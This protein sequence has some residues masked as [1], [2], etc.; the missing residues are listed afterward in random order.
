M[1]W[2]NFDWD[3]TQFRKVP[4]KITPE[5]QPKTTLWKSEWFVMARDQ[6]IFF[7][8][9]WMCQEW[10]IV[11][12]VWFILISSWVSSCFFRFFFPFFFGCGSYWL[13]PSQIFLEHWALPN[14]RVPLWTAQIESNVLPQWPTI[15]VYIHESW[16]MS[17]KTEVLLNHLGEQ[18]G[19]LENLMKRWCE[20]IGN[21]GKRAK[22]EFLTS[23]C[24]T[25]SLATQLVFC[26]HFGEGEWPGHKLWYIVEL[27][28]ELGQ[29]SHLA[30]T[31]L[32]WI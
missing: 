5:N 23:A 20:R 8:L 14:R 28:Q 30:M 4:H 19:K 10:D 16:T 7:I 1:H 26:H 22:N 17:N 21:K 31:F 15:S 9:A 2:L 13:A 6:E 3:I 18:L 12:L 24:W 29:R 25:F 11:C 27:K 32:S